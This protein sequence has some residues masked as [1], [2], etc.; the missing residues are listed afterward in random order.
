MNRD[1][2]AAVLTAFCFGF[3]DLVDDAFW[4]SRV[5]ML[6]ESLNRFEKIY[7]WM[8]DVKA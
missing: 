7:G 8:L 6:R 1:D 5:L 2:A 3:S 4:V